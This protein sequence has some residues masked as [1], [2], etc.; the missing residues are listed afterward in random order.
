MASLSSNR[1]NTGSPWPFYADEVR[2]VTMKM[3]FESSDMNLF[4]EVE[5]PAQVRKDSKCTKV[6]ASMLSDMAAAVRSGGVFDSQSTAATVFDCMRGC[7][8]NVIKYVQC[9]VY[10]LCETCRGKFQQVNAEEARQLPAAWDHPGPTAM[11]EKGGTGCDASVQTETLEIQDL[12]SHRLTGEGGIAWE[13]VSSRHRTRAR[14]KLP[15]PLEGSTDR[16]SASPTSPASLL[17]RQSILGVTTLNDSSAIEIPTGQDMN[18]KRKSSS[19]NTTV[20]ASSNGKIQEHAGSPVESKRNTVVSADGRHYLSATT[21]GSPEEIAGMRRDLPPVPV[22][23][24]GALRVPGHAKHDSGLASALSARV[25]KSSA[26]NASHAPSL[27]ASGCS[28][29]L[30]LGKE[31]ARRGSSTLSYSSRDLGHACAQDDISN[32]DAELG[33]CPTSEGGT[34]GNSGRIFINVVQAENTLPLAKTTSHLSTDPHFLDL[35]KEAGRAPSKVMPGQQANSSAANGMDVGKQG[36]RG[37]L[38]ESQ[39]HFPAYKSGGVAR[40]EPSVELMPKG[41]GSHNDPELQVVKQHLLT[42]DFP[43]SHSIA[44]GTYRS[45]REPSPRPLSRTGSANSLGS[46]HGISSRRSSKSPFGRQE[47]APPALPPLPRKSLTRASS[48]GSV[49]L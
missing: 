29:K 5:V 4:F 38:T 40:Q 41:F 22:S 35:D 20:V 45:S 2:T 3:T 24:L 36:S 44:L 46:A 14:D 26:F 7:V 33:N 21:P 39:L 31:D 37:S 42:V 6:V 10:M 30:D 16:G 49:G 18:S 9:P 19:S 43:A 47:S 12:Q 34:D 25:Q 32:R 23:P 1:S 17:G 11:A 15:L 8:S 27:E 48:A 13:D 28:Y